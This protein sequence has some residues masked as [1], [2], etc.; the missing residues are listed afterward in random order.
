MAICLFF[1]FLSTLTA[2]E[3]SFSEI[4][5]SLPPLFRFHPESNFGEKSDWKQWWTLKLDFSTSDRLYGE[6]KFHFNSKGDWKFKKKKKTAS[7]TSSSAYE[8]SGDSSKR[9]K[10]EKKTVECQLVTTGQLITFKD[11]SFVSE[12]ISGSVHSFPAMIETKQEKKSGSGFDRITSDL[13]I[14]DNFFFFFYLGKIRQSTSGL[15]F[16]RN[17][18]LTWTI[19]GMK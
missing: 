10:E 2:K 8:V 5:Q 17:Q 16:I 12:T 11:H 18:S 15:F 9:K 19:N 13:T 4:S 1:F 14:C 3:K 7:Q 6:K